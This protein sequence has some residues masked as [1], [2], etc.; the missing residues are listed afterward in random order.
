[1]RPYQWV[2]NLLVFVPIITAHALTE[3]NAWATGALMFAAFCAAASGI[4]LI[5]DIP[6]CPAT[7]SIFA[8]EIGLSLVAH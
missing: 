8:S 5:N 7:G 1:M 6:T 2:K 3:L 4:Y